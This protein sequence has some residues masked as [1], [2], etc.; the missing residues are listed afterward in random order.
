MSTVENGGITDQLYD[1]SY[2]LFSG[3]DKTLAKNCV[4]A[5]RKNTLMSTGYLFGTFIL[6]VL[7]SGAA[8][9]IF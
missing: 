6:G 4:A 9:Y 3:A 5:R 8:N 1:V 2:I 7:A